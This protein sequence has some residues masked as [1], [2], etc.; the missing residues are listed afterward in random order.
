MAGYKELD[1][2]VWNNSG[3]GSGEH[4]EQLRELGWFSLEKRRL[5]GDL[6]TLHS[7]LKGGRS[8]VEV[9]HFSQGTSD[10]TRGNDL[11]LC[12]RRFRLDIGKTVFMA[13]VVQHWQRLPRAG[14][15]SP[16]LEG[17]KIRAEV[18]LR[19]MVIGGLG[20]VG[21]WLLLM[22]LSV[23]SSLNDCKMLWMDGRTDGHMRCSCPALCPLCSSCSRARGGTPIAANPGRA[24]GLPGHLQLR[25]AAVER[26]QGHL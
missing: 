5:R 4:V 14:V 22:L 8:E 16:S 26:P 15:E 6:I 23:F 25:P 1:V 20:S 12:Q 3:E 2:W 17:L 24:D 19:D 21:F 13:R 18:V 9:C 11:T 10:R 7:Y